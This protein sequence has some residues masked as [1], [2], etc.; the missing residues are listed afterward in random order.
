MWQYPGSTKVLDVSNGALTLL[1]EFFSPTFQPPGEFVYS[2]FSLF[3][4]GGY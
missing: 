2:I 4:I 1:L 3:E